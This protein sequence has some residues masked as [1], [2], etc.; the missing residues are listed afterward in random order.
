MR[1]VLH[2]GMGKTGTSSIQKALEANQAGLK[3]Q[4]AHYLGM[5]FDFIDQRYHGVKG[6]RNAFDQTPDALEE[7]AEAT[8]ERMRDI[9]VRDGAD[10]FIFSNEDLYGRIQKLDP[11][12]SVLKRSL[13]LSIV[14]YVRDIHSWLPS[15]YAQWGI[16]HKVRQGPVRTFAEDAPRLVKAYRAIAHWQEKHGPHMVFRKYD[17]STD[18]IGD[19]AEVIGKKLEPSRARHLE[20]GEPVE[21]LL[22]AVFNDRFPGEVFPGKFNRAVVNTHAAPVPRLEAVIEKY[23]DYST[24]DAAIAPDREVLERISA[25]I[26]V[27]FLNGSKEMV[28]TPVRADLEDRLFDYMIAIV[29]NQAQRIQVLENTVRDLKA[30]NG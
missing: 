20:R 16:H 17:K 24:V 28:P 21:L 5:W 22:R 25:G 26:G 14:I 6:T 3:A 13:D 4:K 12:L 29:L 7:F 11:F 2:V 27:D 9:Q 30:E 15:A 1:L 10:T 23:L 18:V 19:F 8:V